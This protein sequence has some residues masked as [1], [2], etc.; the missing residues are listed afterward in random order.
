MPELQTVDLRLQLPEVWLSERASQTPSFLGGSYITRAHS[1]GS[2]LPLEN[3][4][5]RYCREESDP[6]PKTLGTLERQNFIHGH[7]ELWPSPRFR[8]SGKP[9]EFPTLGDAIAQ[10][11]KKCGYEVLLEPRALPKG[12]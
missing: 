10:L 7:F 4:M 2:D 9:L 8:V 11:S 3:G 6:L 5:V 12:D 1:A